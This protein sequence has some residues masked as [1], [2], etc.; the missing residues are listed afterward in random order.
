VSRKSTLQDQKSISKMKK[1]RTLNT[2]KTS[3]DSGD[4]YIFDGIWGDWSGN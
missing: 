3:S 1:M 4:Y 2:K